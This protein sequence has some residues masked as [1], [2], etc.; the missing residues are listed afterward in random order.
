MRSHNLGVSRADMSLKSP[1]SRRAAFLAHLLVAAL[2]VCTG[3]G[4][5]GPDFKRPKVAVSENW[6]D[7]GDRRVD[8]EATTYRNWPGST[9]TCDLVINRRARRTYR[10]VLFHP[11]STTCRNAAEPVRPRISRE[12]PG[13]P[14]A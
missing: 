2:L 5:V 11:E 9:R 10:R 6:L 4:V 8:T 1:F 3:C 14:S 7:T 12:I 13:K